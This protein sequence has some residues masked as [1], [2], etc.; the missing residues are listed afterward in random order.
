M[1]CENKAIRAHSIQNSGVI[2]LLAIDGHVI[3]PKLVVSSAGPEVKFLPV[4][5][6]N[7]STFTG[8]CGN[9][10]AAIFRPLDTHDFDLTDKQQLFL[11]AY[12]SV[13]R[14]LHAVMEGAAKIQS[15]YVWRVEQGIDSGD[16]LSPVGMKA[17][18][19]LINAFETYQYRSSYF[20]RSLISERYT[21]INHD[22]IVLQQHPTIAVS[23]LFSFGSLRRDNEL[24]RCVLNV[25]PTS[26]DTTI[27]VFS[28]VND[29][30]HLV[31]QALDRILSSSGDFQKYEISKLIINRIENFLLSPAYFG[32]WNQVKMNRILSAFIATVMGDKETQDDPDLMLF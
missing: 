22:I 2:D 29:D 10:D 12:R 28:Y 21:D 23:S 17:T 11:L 15:A 25:V 4:G 16:E 24:V 30:T 6:N 31:R 5:R 14:E 26:A 32:S 1:S 19:H 9:H 13:T 7:A 18:D 3:A 8:L 20:D 27:V